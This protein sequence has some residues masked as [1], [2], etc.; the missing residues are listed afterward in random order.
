MRG[1]VW[2]PETR[3]V[4]ATVEEVLGYSVNRL[5]SFDDIY[6]GKMCAALDRQHPRDLF[7]IALLLENE[8]TSRRLLETFLVY[9][10]SHN[11][12]IAE[13][14]AP[15]RLDIRQLF[16]DE[17]EPMTRQSVPFDRLI[18]AREELVAAI[19]TGLTDQNRE[20]LISVK[21]RQPRWNLLG[22]P[23]IA[24]LP[25]VRWKLLNLGRMNASR[26]AAAVARLRRVLEAGTG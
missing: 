11:R 1:A 26:H 20:F 16:E 6:A 13:L 9:L 12:P 18:N 22:M 5:L 4:T 3:P 19:H 15:R 24:D 14:L 10:I 25:A 8:G 17:F 7:D 2:P 21:K 23:G